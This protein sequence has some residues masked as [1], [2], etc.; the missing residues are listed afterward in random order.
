MRTS[1]TTRSK[2]AS[3][4]K[5]S[6]K[7]LEPRS[8]NRA[9]LLLDA[10]AEL[11]AQKGFRGTTMRDI[12]Q[13]AEMLPGS[14][15]YHFPSKDHLLVAIYEQGVERLMKQ[16]E[17]IDPGPTAEPWDRLEAVFTAHLENITDR[18]SYAKVI[19]RV[20]PDAAPDVS[21]QL[22]KLRDNYEK[23]IAS[24]IEALP[25][26]PDVDRKLFR[27][28]VL[29]AANHVQIWHRRGDRPPAEIAAELVAMIRTPPGSS[30]KKS[31]KK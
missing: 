30:A 4:R 31:K 28:F 21:D 3:K 23:F 7:K 11:F 1:Q 24:V 26:H 15:Y 9:K 19:V 8:N 10:A 22:I 6:K 20:V 5:P 29:G 14:I 18:S 27:L 16:I 12:A 25:L 17:A 13:K 2:S